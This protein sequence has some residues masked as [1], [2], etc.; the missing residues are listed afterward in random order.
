M[1]ERFLTEDQIAEFAV[2]LKMEEK[3]KSTIKKYMRDVKTFF[4]YIKGVQI[5]K[6]TVITYTTSLCS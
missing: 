1:E 3:S 5:T 6:E 4:T 2:Y